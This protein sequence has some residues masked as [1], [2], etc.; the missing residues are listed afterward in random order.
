MYTLDF[1]KMHLTLYV[2][3]DAFY[4]LK[5]EYKNNVKIVVK[6]TKTNDKG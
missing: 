5:M 1:L 6:R 4:K 3:L 2:S